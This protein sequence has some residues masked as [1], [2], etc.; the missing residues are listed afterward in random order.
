MQNQ[1][2]L[3]RLE[4]FQVQ[5]STNNLCFPKFSIENINIWKNRAKRA[6]NLGISWSQFPNENSN[7]WVILNIYVKFYFPKRM[8]E[9]RKFQK[10]NSKSWIIQRDNSR[11]GHP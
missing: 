4:D 10:K 6:L 11:L 9:I 2:F 5:P 8:C 7:F 1:S 3:M